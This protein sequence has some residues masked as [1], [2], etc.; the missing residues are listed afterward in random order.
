[1][2]RMIDSISCSGE[3]ARMRQGNLP[4][5]LCLRYEI[6]VRR[7]TSKPKLTA[8]A[9]ASVPA[10]SWV[11]AADCS[12]CSADGSPKTVKQNLKATKP[13]LS[14]IPYFHL[15]RQ[16]PTYSNLLHRITSTAPLRLQ[17]PRRQR[18]R[19]LH[20]HHRVGQHRIDQ[21]VALRH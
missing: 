18:L 11:R 5:A 8:R 21:L 4:S 17:L 2:G 20:R 7:I 12:Q 13:L 1:M 10:R 9:D 19:H 3:P 14:C 6:M 16:H 15:S